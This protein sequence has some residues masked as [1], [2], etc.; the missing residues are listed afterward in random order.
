[1]LTARLDQRTSGMK[2]VRRRV[3]HLQ[4]FQIVAVVA[5]CDE[6]ATT[7]Q[8]RRRVPNTG[9]RERTGLVNRIVTRI[10]SLDAGESSATFGHSAGEQNGARWKSRCGVCSPRGPERRH[11]PNRLF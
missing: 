10:K 9:S 7:G 5:T 3:E 8:Q 6:D 1:M 4:R 2:A 11:P